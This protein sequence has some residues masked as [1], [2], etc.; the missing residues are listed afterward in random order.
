VTSAAPDAERGA[1]PPLGPGAQRV[2]S[3][4]IANAERGV[5]GET[6]SAELA[7][8]RA[9]V[10]KHV[11][12][13]RRRGYAI[14]GIPGGGYRLPSR[15]DRLLPEL[16]SARLAT[17]WLARELHGYDLIDSTNTRALAL[18]RGGSAA[19]TC[20]IAEQQ[21]AGRG[22]LG[23]SFFSPAYQNLYTSL[24]LRPSA[25]LASAPGYILA[26]ATGVAECVAETLGDDAAVEIKWPNDVLVA[27]LKC[28]GILLELGAEATRIAWLVIGIGVNLNVPRNALPEEFRARA[29]SLCTAMGSPID[30]VDF[31]ARLYAKLESAFDA[32]AAAGLDAVRPRFDRFFRMAGRRVR[33]IESEGTEIAGVATG[34]DADGAL[35]LRED[36]GTLRR[37]LA[38]DVT[39][40]KDA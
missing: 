28:S 23:R 36:S 37:V 25:S 2:L 11:E 31:A 3:E 30:R 34:I 33:A 40:A 20:V 5:S 35:I 4:L 19:G 18:A 32:C 27:G 39:L 16:V 12:G 1:I 13:L 10:W 29:T 21:S 24:V 8:S 17:R 14:E 7:I 22:R 15:P 9:Q 26:T 38:A 6:L